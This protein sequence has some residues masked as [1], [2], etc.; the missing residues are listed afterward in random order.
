MFKKRETSE[1]DSVDPIEQKITQ[2]KDNFRGKNKTQLKVYLFFYKALTGII[3]FI[4]FLFVLGFLAANNIINNLMALA[5]TALVLYVLSIFRPRKYAIADVLEEIDLGHEVDYVKMEEKETKKT[6]EK[7]PVKPYLLSDSKKEEILAYPEDVLKGIY[8]LSYWEKYKDIGSYYPIKKE[9]I[10]EDLD[11]ELF[12]T[13]DFQKGMVHENNFKNIINMLL[14][15]NL[16]GKMTENS[17]FNTCVKNVEALTEEDMALIH[18]HYSFLDL[19]EKGKE[20]K[21]KLH[22]LTVPFRDES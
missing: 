21:H 11:Q 15:L 8:Y 1:K 4:S 19:T 6:K 22:R 10:P 2:L 20:A 12:V 9:K 17:Y 7:S 16:G 13:L 14:D 3:V 18:D 5:L